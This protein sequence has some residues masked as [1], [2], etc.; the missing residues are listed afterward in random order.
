MEA[1]IKKFL[2]FNGKV[3]SF[4]TIDGTVWIAIKPICQ[5]LGI[6][7]DRQYKN[8]KKSKLF[9]QLYA[10][11]H[12]TGADFKQYLMV[13]LQ[14]KHIYGWLMSVDSDNQLLHEYQLKCCDILY[15]YF[16]GSITQRNRILQDIGTIE[17]Q[18][19]ELDDKFR[20][21]PDYIKMLS[22]KG[23][24]LS[25]YKQVRE[26]DSNAIQMELKFN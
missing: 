24:E 4:C 10:K 13:S 1:R 5:A 11:Q 16:H 14:E 20:A 17:G 19:K 3:L 21:D 15:D 12:M 2:E 9:G 22:L 18:I 25:L 23:K 8:L 26:L 6:N 7:Y